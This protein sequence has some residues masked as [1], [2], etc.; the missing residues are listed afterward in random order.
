MGW[1]SFAC[2]LSVLAVVLY[3]VVRFVQLLRSDCDLTCA[4]A[5]SKVPGKGAYSEKVVWVVGA[6]SGIGQEIAIEYARQGA[7]V[8]LSARRV[9]RLE[10]VAARCELVGGTAQCVPLD[11]T[12]LET[13]KGIVQGILAEHQA[14]DILVTLAPM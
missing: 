5:L 9:E 14:I 2:L 7:H 8:I 11:V 3:A 1:L 4:A 10:K 12:K 13:H 6:S